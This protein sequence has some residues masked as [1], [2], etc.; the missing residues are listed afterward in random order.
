M[1]ESAAPPS[2]NRFSLRA[3]ITDENPAA[4]ERLRAERKANRKQVSADRAV[5]RA[6]AAAARFSSAVAAS[7]LRE[8]RR[9]YQA[10]LSSVAQRALRLVAKF[11][12]DET[13][14]FDPAGGCFLFQSGIDA[15]WEVRW[16]DLNEIR[17]VI[18]RRQFSTSGER[19]IYFGH[20]AVAANKLTLVKDGKPTS[21]VKVNPN[22]LSLRPTSPRH[23]EMDGDL[24]PNSIELDP[25]Q[26][27]HGESWESHAARERRE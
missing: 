18:R 7:A 9:S 10:N 14:S 3:G 20:I 1:T 26:I 6:A 16:S 24:D 4:T 15:Y 12:E 22:T 23:I 21:S 19:Y 8:K 17:L 2:G 27:A 11:S 13:L 25:D 5:D